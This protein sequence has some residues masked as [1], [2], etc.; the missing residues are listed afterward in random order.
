MAEVAQ[1]HR[2]PPSKSLDSDENFKLE[3][4]LFCCELRFV[5]IYALYGDLWSKK[6]PF[7]VKNSVFWVRSALL[8]GIYCIL[9]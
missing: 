8:L 4:T 3:H 6:V 1:G 2:G 5:A 7:G 9:Y